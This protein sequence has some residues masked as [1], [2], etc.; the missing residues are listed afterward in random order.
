MELRILLQAARKSGFLV[1][2]AALLGAILGLT[3]WYVLPDAYEASAVI[4]TDSTAITV[5]GQQPFVGDP[6]RYVTGELESLRS[7]P[8]ASLAA[9]SLDPP[10]TPEELLAAIKL[11]HITGSDVVEVTA[12]AETPQRASAM[13][14]AVAATYIDRR[15]EAAQAALDAQRAALED[16]AQQLAARLAD[17]QLAEPVANALYA[18]YAQVNESIAELAKPGVLR[19][20]TR[21]VDTGR[22]AVSTRALGPVPT[23]G[24][25]GLLGG[26]AGLGVAVVR[27]LRRPRVTGREE[28]EFLS[29]RPVSVDFPHVRGLS[30]MTPEGLLQSLAA[31]AGRLAALTS[32]GAPELGPLV[33]T[34]CSATSP[35][36]CSTVATALASRLADDGLRV[37]AVT[38]GGDRTPLALSPSTSDSAA[39]PKTGGS[40]A[41]TRLP[42]AGGWH[43]A[44]GVVRGLTVM[45]HS[46]PGPLTAEDYRKALTE[47]SSAADVVVVDGSSVLDSAFAGVAVRESHRVV[48]V[49]PALD[50]P[51]SDLR[52]A[53]DLLAEAT[54]APVHVAVTHL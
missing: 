8:V 23:I 18:T 6:E 42:A 16:Q 28:V 20:A 31:P 43:A 7:Y 49:V 11:T 13:A 9:E 12:R 37:T 52:L 26:L 24:G 29:G 1:A 46:G 2:S 53:L 44:D 32:A 34:C 33:I 4:V 25:A 40:S 19:D 47:H 17:G 36:G 27:T 45:S 5:P 38:V 30:R 41:A 22:A 39:G 21:V 3:T 10:P 35:A 50:Q 51:E 54:D 15:T 14:N 48:L